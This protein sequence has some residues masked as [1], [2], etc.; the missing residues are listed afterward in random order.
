MSRYCPNK[1]CG[2]WDDA[3]QGLKS[4]KANFCSCCC[5]PLVTKDP[6]DI[7]PKSYNI[8]DD[9]SDTADDQTVV[10]PLTSAKI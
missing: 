8:I 10:L 4:E 9:P 1:A 7:S 5:L 6:R 2:F 3:P